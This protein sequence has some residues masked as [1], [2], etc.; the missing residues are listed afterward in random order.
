MGLFTDDKG[1][2]ELVVHPDIVLGRAT[3]RP[4]D[5]QPES[6]PKETPKQRARREL[7]K[8]MTEERLAKQKT[9]GTNPEKG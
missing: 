2:P 4:V 6:E 9:E 8:R 5:D 1:R 3:F 7:K